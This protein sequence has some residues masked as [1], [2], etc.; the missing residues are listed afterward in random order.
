ML[1]GVQFH[2]KYQAISYKNSLALNYFTQFNQILTEILDSDGASNMVKELI[3]S[4]KQIRNIY[5]S[6]NGIAQMLEVP[7]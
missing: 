7:Q 1:K 4:Y 6:N 5:E 2:E 3:V